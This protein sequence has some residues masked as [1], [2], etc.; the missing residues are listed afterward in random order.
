MR[1]NDRGGWGRKPRAVL[2]TTARHARV[3]TGQ[4]LMNTIAPLRVTAPAMRR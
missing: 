1:R 3:M 4:I 2:L